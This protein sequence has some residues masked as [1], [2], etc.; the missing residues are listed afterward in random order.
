MVNKINQVNTKVSK[1]QVRRV[2]SRLIIIEFE[3]IQY[4]KVKIYVPLT[5]QSVE[6]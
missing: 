1:Q 6:T 3:R 4:S 2:G 5:K